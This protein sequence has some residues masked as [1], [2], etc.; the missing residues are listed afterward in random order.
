MGRRGWVLVVVAVFVLAGCL[1]NPAS[2]AAGER[3]EYS[4]VTTRPPDLLPS[5]GGVDDRTSDIDDRPIVIGEE[6]IGADDRTIGVDDVQPGQSSSSPS[7]ST[8]TSPGTSTETPEYER[9]LTPNHPHRT[10]PWGGSPVVVAV[11]NHANRSR[12]VT[13]LVAQAIEY[14]AKNDDRYGEYSVDFTLDAD[15]DDP[16]VVVR[17]QRTVE[18]RGETGWLGCAPDV[19]ATD[20]LPHPAVVSIRSGFTNE[21]TLDTI[22]HEF[23]HLLGI[24]HGEPPM[25]IMSPRQES[26]T[27]PSPDADEREF[28][29][30]DRNLSVFV[31]YGALSSDRRIEVARQVS[32]AIQYY[33]ED[34]NA[35]AWNNVSF[36]TAATREDADVVIEFGRGSSIL[37]GPGSF[38]R[39]MGPDTDGDDRVEYYTR[40]EIV[41]QDVRTEAIGW[42]VGYWMGISLGATD[43]SEL[44]APFR[45]GT[46]TDDWWLTPG[47]EP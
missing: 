20:S 41:I 36:D 24:G 43:E 25:P 28:P 7:S 10:N 21:S 15:A 39:P 9:V 8:A 31:D 12:N 44:P 33:Q 3:T 11:E 26:M 27:L 17:F 5:P 6:T 18:C 22:K 23:G 35:S 1:V 13:A 4:T 32:H 45:N 42:H 29:W 46:R 37:E 34:V 14:W 47:E 38:G 16:D 40:S 19:E 2:P 30:R